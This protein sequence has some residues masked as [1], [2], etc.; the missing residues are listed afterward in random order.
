[1]AGSKNCYSAYSKS[2]GTKASKRSLVK[3]G[4]KSASWPVR[5][6]ITVDNRTFF[7]TTLAVCEKNVAFKQAVINAFVE[8]IDFSGPRSRF[9]I[10]PWADGYESSS[11]SD[12]DEWIDRLLSPQAMEEA[13][14]RAMK[15]EAARKAREQERVDAI[16]A[17]RT[18][19]RIE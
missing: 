19:H 12:D 4:K 14:E 8:T 9:H 17:A 15:E 5:P 7:E 10:Q 13:I 11:S 3:R 6:D 16:I 18:V 1:M 2:R